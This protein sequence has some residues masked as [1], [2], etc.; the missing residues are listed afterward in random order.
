MDKNLTIE[1]RIESLYVRVIERDKLVAVSFIIAKERFSA[2]FD[3]NFT[4]REGDLV[5]VSYEQ[6][7]GLNKIA[8]VTLLAHS[9]KHASP[10]SKI[11]NAL[12]MIWYFALSVFI[13]IVMIFSM[14]VAKFEWINIIIGSIMLYL[15]YFVFNEG[16]QIYKISRHFRKD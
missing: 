14:F 11:T 13:F 1:G 6:R 5:R 10:A 4:F 7:G 16:L 9:T 12:A 8:Q 3:P 2:E 15:S